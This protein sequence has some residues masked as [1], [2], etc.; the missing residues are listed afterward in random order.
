MAC[1][2]SSGKNRHYA[3]VEGSY[4]EAAAVSAAERFTSLGL[5]L[6]V[7]QERPRRRDKTGTR[8]YQ[9]ISG[10]LRKRIR[11][12]LGT[13]L[14]Q[15]EET[16][17][18][19]RYGPLVEAAMGGTPAPSGGGATVAALNGT[20]IGFG[21]AHGLVAG[22][23][24]A[25]GGEVR[26]VESVASAT[27]VVVSAPFEEATAGMATGATVT[28]P[29]AHD[30]KSVTVYDYWSPETAVQRILAGGAVDEMSID[31]N[32][33]FHEI[34]FR[35]EAAEMIDSRTFMAG[36]AGLA[37]FPAEPALGAVV[38][39]PVPGHL[40]QAWLGTG[41]E[42]IHTVKSARI[43]IKNNI[44]FRRNDFG[45]LRARC[46]APGDRAVSVELELYSQDRAVF[47]ELYEAARLRNGLPLMIQMGDAPGR[48]C[49]VW[50]PNF[51]PETPEFLDDEP[52]LR[53]RVRSSQAQ[54]TAEDEIHVA[55]A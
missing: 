45:S 16:S 23:A 35:G 12:E 18:A 8:T 2:I 42:R 30:L 1:Y 14:Y 10:E 28:Y 33:D 46:L 11:F 48:M 54:G 24:L 52:R 39:T 51:V 22:Q 17:P 40:G 3:A 41:P 36:Q 47:S 15:R 20:Q 53:W 6:E 37:S 38:E 50:A 44:E 55:F 34:T 43:A 5:R 29:L 7:N 21:G 25:I 27:A 26:M 13:Y 32:G 4:G 49:C 31:V 19:A 9:G